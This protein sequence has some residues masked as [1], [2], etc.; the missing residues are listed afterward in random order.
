MSPPV[1]ARAGIPAEPPRDLSRPPDLSGL[2]DGLF[3]R[4]FPI[5]RSITGP[6]IEKS[7][8]MIGEYMPLDIRKIA[9]GET[10]FDWEVPPEWVCRAARL[11]APNGS[12]VADLARSNLHVVNFA[13]AV[14]AR[15]AL[16]ELQPHLHSLPELPDAIPYVTSYYKRNWGF[17][18]PDRIRRALPPGVY[19]AYIDAEFRQG[20]VPV[21]QAVLPGTTQD[22]VLISSYLCHPSLAN[23]ELS[24]PL[25]L[26]GLYLRLKDWPR[27]RL[28]YRFVLN[29]ETIGSLCY[30]HLHARPLRE[31][32]IAGLV[33]TCTGGPV[34]Q[35]SYKESR[36]GLGLLD[37]LV[38][39]LAARAP[40]QWTIRPFTPCSG[41]DER[42]YC[43]PGFDLPVGQLARTVYGEY[44]GYHNSLDSKEFMNINSVMNSIDGIEGL[45][46]ALESAAVYCNLKPYGEPQLGKRGLYPTANAASTWKS[47]SDTVIDDRAA[48]ER[49]L[50]VLNY[51]D[52]ENDTIDIAD[53][54]GCTVADLAPTVARL[55]E[56]GL[57]RFDRYRRH[58]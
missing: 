23:N 36:R 7:M 31:R 47:S 54:C 6:G 53:R 35:L 2:L 25:T 37:R 19:H 12:V 52:G 17:C 10:V 24:G 18:L 8:G 38:R 39:H 32:M 4:L 50:M 20:G 26:L 16:S 41:S 30:L 14:D 56:A 1:S 48:L 45:L 11:T 22:E 44:E 43:S 28:T 21:A 9:T 51:S 13:D 49:I 57:L 29:P 42:Q 34:R 5:L 46:R 55:E 3:T 58:P 15:M 40:D 27:R 33:L